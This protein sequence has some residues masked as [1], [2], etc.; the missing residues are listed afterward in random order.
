MLTAPLLTSLALA[1]NVTE[2]PPFLRG[3]VTV[4]YAY[5]QLAGSLVERSEGEDV[6]VAQRTVSA[7]QMRYALTFGAG[8]GAAVFLEIPQWI[9]DDVSYSSLSE[10]VYDPA[11]GKG[12]YQGTTAGEDGTYVTGSGLGGVWIG[13]KGTPFSESFK[14]R[15]N[16][17]T[18]LLE[19]AL[20]T[21]DGSNYWTM[22]DGNRGAGNGGT[23]VRLRTAFSTTYGTA[24]PY[25]V[26]TYVHEGKRTVD[27]YDQAGTLLQTGVEVD[28]ADEGLVRAGLEVLAAHNPANGSKLGFDLH[29][30]ADYQS[31]ATLPSGFYLPRVLEASAGQAVQSAEQL[32]PGAGLGFSWRP[33]EYMQ[34]DVYGDLAWHLPQ[35]VESPY[36]VYTGADTL[37]LVAGSNLTVRIR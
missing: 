23:A 7:N 11:T 18:W 9:S 32:E 33:M 16:R 37:H 31:Y 29:M 12:T 27:V 6:D 30:Q 10:M 2:L 26:G 25:V 34:L 15:G 28:P 13:A 4:G 17:A 36:A 35:R 3:D 5:D 22:S 19:G 24:Q 8:P 1:A 20:R 14:G 21:G